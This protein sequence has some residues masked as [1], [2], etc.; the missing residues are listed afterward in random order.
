M[1]ATK[2][3][4]LTLAIQKATERFTV[5]VDRPTDN[6]LIEIRQLLVP[7]LMKTTYDELT[8]QHTLAGV[9]LPTE[10]YEQ[11]YKKGAYAIPPIIPLYDDNIDKDAT[12]LEINRAEGRHE[13]KR[14]DVV[15]VK[16]DDKGNHISPF[17]VNLFTTFHR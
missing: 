12:R 11:I 10:R 17:L 1:S 16:W 15:I 8:L 9:I 3:A 5:I 14:N 13:A 4:E 2:P 6:D 7:V